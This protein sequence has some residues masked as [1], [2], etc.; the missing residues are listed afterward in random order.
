[1]SVNVGCLIVT[2]VCTNLMQL[3]LT[4]TQRVQSVAMRVLPYLTFSIKMYL[5]KV[6]GKVHEMLKEWDSGQLYYKFA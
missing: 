2:D 4:V 1:M 6:Y 5:Q 3:L